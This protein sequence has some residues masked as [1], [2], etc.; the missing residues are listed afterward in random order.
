MHYAI[1]RQ[2]DRNKTSIRWPNGSRI[3]IHMIVN[4]EY[5]E[6]G[7]PSTSINT[8]FANLTPD[9]YNHSWRDY[10]V[11][12]GLWRMMRIFDKHQVRPSVALNALVCNH[13]PNI[14]EEFKRRQ[15]EI[16][17]HGLTTSQLL[18]NL[19]VEVERQT[20]QET[21]DIIERATGTRPRGWLG[22]A[23]AESWDTPRLL[24]AAGIQYVCDWLNDDEP[25]LLET[26]DS[27]L[28]SMPYSGEINDIHCFLRAGY[29][30][31]DYLQLLKDQFDTLY[32]EGETSGTVMAIPLHPFI[33]GHPFR[34]KYLD[35]AITYIASK[36]G[37]W[38]TTGS[39]IADAYL[40][41]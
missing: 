15:W 17:G 35:A 7:V 23:L 29:N 2:I 36:P 28:L 22:P 21:L 40:S 6:P 39:Q 5:Y 16:M 9:V 3:A 14:V 34:A 26:P 13:Y 33:T 19:P 1:P 25:Y 32:D 8:A 30:A 37:V 24:E 18:T 31:P 27:K 38:F 4:I 10:G 11:R 12:T 20:I 41:L